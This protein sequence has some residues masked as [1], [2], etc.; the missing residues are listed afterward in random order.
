MWTNVCR[1][2]C[3]GAVVGANLMIGAQMASAQGYA[4]PQDP[5]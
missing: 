2:V 5:R 3:V 4:S 1:H